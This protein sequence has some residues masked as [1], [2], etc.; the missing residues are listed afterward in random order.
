MN[1]I[2]QTLQ[3]LLAGLVLTGCGGGGGGG[4]APAPAPQ[5]NTGSFV[6]S[7]VMGLHYQTP[8]QSGLT[9]SAGE[10]AYLEGE[11]VTF[12]LGGIVL[13]SAAGAQELTPLD[14]L[15]ASSIDDA[16]AQG[17]GDALLNMLVLLQSLDRD[18]NPDNGI[19]LGDLHTQLSDVELNFAQSAAEFVQAAQQQ[20]LHRHARF[21][22]SQDRARRHFANSQQLGYSLALPELDTLDLNEDGIVDHYIRYRHDEQGR[23]IDISEG[24][25]DP[26]SDGA[27]PTR[28]LELFY[29]AQGQLVQL[30]YDDTVNN[31]RLLT[32]DYSYGDEGQ[33]IRIGNR[34]T[35]EIPLG[36]EHW[37]YSTT[38]ELLRYEQSMTEAGVTL[39][40]Q[41]QNPYDLYY[42]LQAYNPNVELMVDVPPLLARILPEDFSVGIGGEA[43]TE[44]SYEDNGSLAT[45]VKNR[46]IDFNL[47]GNAFVVLATFTHSYDEGRLLRRTTRG[48]AEFLD[49]LLETTVDIHYSPGGEISRCDYRSVQSGASNIVFDSTLEPDPLPA[50]TT[51]RCGDSGNDET[52][53]TH[54]DNGQIVAITRNVYINSSHEIQR[55]EQQLTYNEGRTSSV[56]LTETTVNTLIDTETVGI[57]LAREYGYT[58]SGQLSS[59]TERQGVDTQWTRR[60]QT[61]EIEP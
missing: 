48:E 39:F 26:A 24:P 29:D 19:D 61:L 7:A 6:D 47:N 15:G 27:S 37:L 4:S 60:Y 52:Y 49:V 11:T 46:A 50:M 58:A 8:T 54:D 56:N 34:G 31:I 23:L 38:G 13:G 42:S 18:F 25:E 2:Q 21:F 14:L 44:Y 30:A 17:A 53:I 1:A 43:V 55:S 10:F 57:I 41:Q 20:G 9:N 40:A 51:Y 5:T 35:D 33:L 32:R 16:N 12:S 22:I 59:I 28:Q 36:E 45:T 3:L